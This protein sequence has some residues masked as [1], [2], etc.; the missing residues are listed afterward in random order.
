VRKLREGQFD[1]MVLAGAGLGR[2]GM[3]REI[4]QAFD[5]EQMLPAPGQGAI[6]IEA[7]A[8]GGF[9]EIW[10]SLDDPAIRICVE[11]ERE[12]VRELGADCRSA[13]GA[14][15]ELN[16]ARVRFRAIV[17]SPDGSRQLR[18][19]ETCEPC[20]ASDLASRVAKQLLGQGAAEL[21]NSSAA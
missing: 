7:L 3:Q 12:F 1:A 21:L 20:A 16:D 4:A 18:A 6:C 10:R 15:C 14:H 5:F 2:L 19:D 11:A 8:N 13:A 17:V 9:S